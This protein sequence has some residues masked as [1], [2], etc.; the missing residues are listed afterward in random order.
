MIGL[1]SAE[2]Q[3]K[4]QL[5]KEGWTVKHRGWPDFACIRG[6][7]MI[8]IE[9]KGFRGE[10]LS[11]DQHYI[12]TN[13][14]KLGVNCFKWTP[15]GGYERITEVTQLPKIEPRK[16]KK[17]RRLTPEERWGRLSP[18]EQERIKKDESEGKTRYW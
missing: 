10:M 9:V 18:E 11:E 6:D 5:V 8:V 3:L 14:A 16:D 12:L 1:K 4:E 7:E 13:L 15:D 2:A 17:G